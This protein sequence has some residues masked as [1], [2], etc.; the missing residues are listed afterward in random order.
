[1]AFLS[2][3]SSLLSTAMMTPVKTPLKAMTVVKPRE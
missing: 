1:M 3:S 2:L